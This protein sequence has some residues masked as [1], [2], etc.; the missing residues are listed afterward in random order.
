MS[1]VLTIEHPHILAALHDEIE[2][3]V[4]ALRAATVE[5]LPGS[6]ISGPIK[7]ARWTLSGDGTTVRAEIPDDVDPDQVAAVIAA[8]D[9]KTVEVPQPLPTRD[10]RLRTTI[11][12][13]KAALA[14]ASTLAQVKAV[15]SATLDGLGDAI[16]GGSA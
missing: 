4:P 16:T 2:V 1:I 10:E 9:P 12:Q 14:G 7:V 3:A 11:E 8:H 5:H 15:F 13:G 6:P